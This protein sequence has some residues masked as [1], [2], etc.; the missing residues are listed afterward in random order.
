MEKS[1]TSFAGSPNW[2]KGL[3][4]NSAGEYF[5]SRASLYL[6]EVFVTH[7]KKWI[8]THVAGGEVSVVQNV[9]LHAGAE[10][11]NTAGTQHSAE[12]RCSV[13]NWLYDVHGK[14]LACPKFSAAQN[15]THYL[16]RPNFGLWN[17]F[18]LG[19]S[20]KE[21]GAL[22]YFG[23]SLGLPSGFLSADAFW[24]GKEVDYAVPYPRALMKINYDDGLHVAR[25]H[26]FSFGPM[27]DES[28]YLWELGPDNSK[29]SCS[30]S[31]QMVKLRPDLRAHV[32]RLM[33]LRN[34]E[35]SDLGWADL[36][37]W[38]ESKMPDME[39]PI[40]RN[41]FAVWAS[42]YGNGYVMPELYLGGRLLAL[43]YLVEVVDEHG[44]TRNKNYVEFYLHKS[45]PERF[46]DNLLEKFIF[47][48]EQ[49]AREDDELCKKL[50][51]AHRRT[52]IAFDRIVHVELEAG[53][54]H[55]RRWFLEHATK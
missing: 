29:C 16:A 31:I 2:Y 50:W 13:H 4:L 55:F 44:I 34:K 46:R 21:L 7:D 25:Y 53:E 47:A 32:E 54:R 48:Y 12:I 36:H 35:L 5:G 52:D 18:V 3:R 30:Y 41:I 1:P 6:D 26:Q 10:I 33:D 22:E 8:V 17:G 38:L 45:I 24:F 51:A 20:Q 27:A 14:L 43:S 11:L 19:Y 39:T 9:C 23:A 28:E 42:I 40:D 49:S 37:F 15:S